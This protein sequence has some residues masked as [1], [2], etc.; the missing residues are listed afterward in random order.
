MKKDRSMTI[1][2]VVEAFEGGIIEFI[3]KLVSD[4]RCNHFV[5]HG[6]R[7]GTTIYP[8]EFY[9][10]YVTLIP[11]QQAQREISLLRDYKAYKELTYHLNKIIVH[12]RIVLHLHSA[13]AG[14]LGRLYG[15]QKKI[16]NVVIYTP[17]G[18][19]FARQD[20]SVLKRSFYK[21]IEWI[22]AKMA[23]HVVCVSKSEA[24]LYRAFDTDVDY[25]NNGTELFK[26]SAQN[27]KKV[28]SQT[29][30]V[31]TVGRISEQKSPITFNSIASAFTD[32][33]RIQF[34]WIGDGE[35][36]HLLNSENILITGWMPKEN[37]MAELL[38]CH[39]YLSTAKWEG[40]PFAVIEAMS[41]GL[42]LLLRECVGNV[43]LVDDSNGF[44]FK[45]ADEA[46]NILKKLQ[47]DSILLNQLG[48]ASYNK[49][50]KEFNSEKMKEMYFK[51]YTTKVSDTNI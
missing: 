3:R 12:N 30:K 11:W 47:S 45:T 37:V 15:Y 38:S 33:V 23:G 13:K 43:D 20:V 4:S 2:H 39:L 48:G 18:A 51:L 36:R 40:L 1:V 7:S 19:P 50:M 28:Q 41:L 42:P 8:S 14:I 32:D 34:V 5:I 25:I 44:L 16:S 17:N 22:F 31:V 21:S 35:Q 26:R 24:D 10:S 27:F 29:I 46:I 9:E 6:Q 49:V